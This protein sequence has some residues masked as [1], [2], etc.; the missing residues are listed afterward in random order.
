MKPITTTEEKKEKKEY[1]KE[2]HKEYNNKK[3]I[4]NKSNEKFD[5]ECGG[6]YTRENRNALMGSKKHNSYKDR[7]ININIT[8]NIKDSEVKITNENEVR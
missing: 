2:Y 6:R 3:R 7:A 5:C 4:D 1:Y 8:F